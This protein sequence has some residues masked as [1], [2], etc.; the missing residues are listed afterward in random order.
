MLTGKGFTVTRLRLIIL[1]AA[2][3]GFVLWGFVLMFP[4][5]GAPVHAAYLLPSNAHLAATIMLIGVVMLIIALVASV[6]VIV[7]S[8]RT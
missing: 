7:K 4:F 3:I 1:D 5:Q 2:G 6:L 8:S